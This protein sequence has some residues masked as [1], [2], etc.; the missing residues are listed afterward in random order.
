MSR[1]GADA[2]MG[3][4]SVPD[5]FEDSLLANPSPAML[6]SNAPAVSIGP[7]ALYMASRPSSVPIT[8]PCCRAGFPVYLEYAS[9]GCLLLAVLLLW[10]SGDESRLERLL[11]DCS[12]DPART[13]V[14]LEAV[15]PWL[16][17]DV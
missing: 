1:R 5:L 17:V 6:K 8:D 16:S 13:N 4:E 11:D 14:E 2:D 3:S 12:T 9:G 10:I 7:E 15:R